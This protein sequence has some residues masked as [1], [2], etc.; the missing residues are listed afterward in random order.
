MS[1]SSA[2]KVEKIPSPQST[3]GEGPHWDNETNSLY[4]VDIMKKDFSIH[5]YDVTENKIYSANIEGESYVSFIIPVAGATDLFAVGIGRRVGVIQWDGKSSG[6]KV[7]R[8]VFEVEQT[9]NDGKADPTGRLYCGTITQSGEKLEVFDDIFK[10]TNYTCA[11][12]KYDA[13]NKVVQ[14]RDKVRL[15]NGLA[16][17]EKKKKFYYVDSC[18]LNVKEF[19]YDP[20]T[21]DLCEY[22]P[23]TPL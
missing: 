23:C 22:P 18:D 1:S 9:F 6:A 3:L 21:G 11:L 2:Y 16:W 5:R 19:D 4:Y 10:N 14:V 13:K 17:N 15:S 20:D 12:Y 7:V 8:I